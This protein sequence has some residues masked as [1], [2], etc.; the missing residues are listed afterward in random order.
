MAALRRLGYLGIGLA[1]VGAFVDQC[2]YNGVFYMCFYTYLCY[3]GMYL[4]GS[5]LIYLDELSRV[6][7]LMLNSIK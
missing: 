2:L 6:A 1:G 4:P 3:Y 5:L 7:V